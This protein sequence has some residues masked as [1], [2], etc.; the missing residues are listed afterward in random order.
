VRTVLQSNPSYETAYIALAYTQLGQ[1]QLAQ[2][3][4]SYQKVGKVSPLGASMSASGLADLALYEGRLSDA[5]RMLES[6]AAADLA[7]KNS[8][9]AEKFAMLAYTELWR[10]R[11][12]PALEAATRALANSNK[13]NIRFL[14]ARVLVE[15]GES[16]RARALAAGLGSELSAEAQADAKL[17]EGE[18]A[19]QAKDSKKAIQLFSEGN[20]LLDTWMG[21]FELGRAYLEAGLYVEADSEFDTCIK[22]RGQAMDLLDG[23]TYGYFPPVYYYQGRVREGLKSSGAGD[24]YRTYLSLRGK[25]GEDPLLP[26]IRRHLGQ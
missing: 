6:G 22:W 18:V 12:G 16:A 23:P 3:A 5:V 11:K 26:E 8:R 7:A 13:V 1:G 20:K 19:L 17:I 10:G 15:A 4:E 24:S 9:A 2:A 25:S 21:R 14:M